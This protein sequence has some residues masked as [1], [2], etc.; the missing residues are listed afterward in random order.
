MQPLPKPDRSILRNLLKLHEK[1]KLVS[2]LIQPARRKKEKERNIIF[3]IPTF[4]IF[5]FFYLVNSI[6][7]DLYIELNFF[8]SY[9]IN[10]VE[11]KRKTLNIFF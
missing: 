8:F 4:F 7:E 5:F 1:K 11:E 2:E 9:I 3:S 10:Y 6:C